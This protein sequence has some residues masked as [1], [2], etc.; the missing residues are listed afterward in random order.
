FGECH[1]GLRCR[2]DAP[3][4]LWMW[5]NGLFG[6]MGGEEPGR[7]LGLALS[8]SVVAPAGEAGF[9]GWGRWSGALAGASGLRCAAR[10]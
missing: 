1:I 6:V 3:H 8:A 10:A 4:F 2:A 7:V 9:G 5:R